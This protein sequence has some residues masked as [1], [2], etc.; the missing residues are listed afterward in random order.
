[1]TVIGTMS[2]R[3]WD[4]G[5]FLTIGAY[6][7]TY[8]IDGSLRAAYICDV[9]RVNSGL[10]RFDNKVPV[11]FDAPEDPYQD[12]ILPSLVFK[13]NDLS[14]AFDRQPYAHMVARGPAKD[15]EV[16]TLEDG[17]V[18]YSRYETQ[19]RGDPYDITYD[20]NIWAKEKSV[21]NWIMA[22]V[23]KKLR[24]PWFNFK[25]VD[26]LGDVRYY[27]AGELTFSNTA[28]LADI[29]ER[30]ASYTLSYTVRS[31][32]DTFDEIVSPAMVDPRVVYQMGV[33]H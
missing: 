2:L 14:P 13:Q 9:P 1:V 19:V 15:A 22:Y 4:L 18:G 11:F 32:I 30:Y 23:M 33:E 27:D 29:A 31:E 8:E 20:L 25:V 6:T 28:E 7:T 16:I 3:D 26:S 10:E 12:F 5:C 17:T 24:P 21:A